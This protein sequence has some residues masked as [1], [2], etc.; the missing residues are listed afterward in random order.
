MNKQEIDK[1]ETMYDTYAEQVNSGQK[2]FKELVDEVKEDP[3]IGMGGLGQIALRI[4]QGKCWETYGFNQY[5]GR[6]LAQRYQFLLLTKL[7]QEDPNASNNWNMKEKSFQEYEKKCT[8][9]FSGN[10]PKEEIEYLQ[11]L[12]STDMNDDFSGNWGPE[13]EKGK[14]IYDEFMYNNSPYFTEKPTSTDEIF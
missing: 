13:E 12:P 3:N 14:A 9:I 7:V 11:K 1:E 5:F 6:Q 2:T 4:N 10:T 8:Q